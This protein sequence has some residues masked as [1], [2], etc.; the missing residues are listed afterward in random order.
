M[1]KKEDIKLKFKQ[2]LKQHFPDEKSSVSLNFQSEKNTPTSKKIEAQVPVNSSRLPEVEKV[3][4]GIIKNPSFADNGKMKVFENKTLQIFVQKS[5]H[6][7]QKKFKFQDT[8]FQIR[9][10][11]KKTKGVLLQDVMDI[12]SHTFKYIL[13]HV[14][15]FF[16][17]SDRN[18]AYLCLVQSP[19]L[20]GL[21]TGKNNNH[22]IKKF[23]LIFCNHL[24]NLLEFRLF[25]NTQFK[26]SFWLMY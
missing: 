18:I 15:T 10:E 7:R 8:L 14:K 5:I 16:N 4:D 17:V 11:E 9:V 22:N 20:N 26:T 13:N 24:G 6:Q 2:W 19:M 3:Y 25:I 21:N 23:H 1:A 12:F